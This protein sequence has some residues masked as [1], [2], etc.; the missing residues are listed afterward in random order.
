[1]KAFLPAA[2]LGLVA[3]G[4]LASA[5]AAPINYT[6][7]L[8][9]ENNS[10]VSG[11]G[12]IA[13]DGTLATITI[14][15]TGLAAN[16]AHPSHIHGLL[17]TAAPQTTIAPPSADA[18][19]DGFVEKTEGAPFEGPPV[20]DLPPSGVPGAYSTAPGGVLSFTQTY[21]FANAGLYDPDK[22]GLTLTV[23]DI[24]GLTGGNTVPLV[25]RLVELHGLFVP[26]GVDGTTGTPGTLA[27]DREM[28]V[29]A[30]R[31]QLATTAVP[32][33]GTLLLLGS[34]IAGLAM[35]RRRRAPSPG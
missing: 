35:V 4:A 13:L 12:T 19:A 31:I 9:A 2:T 23:A 21:D 20:F 1:M 32:E 5:H 26:A 3:L 28:P 8:S 15:A 11:S 25:D 29:A 10:G 24:Q 16:Q 22:L 34:G 17:G 7:A 30:G 27:Y 33:P 14:N 18:N 6:F